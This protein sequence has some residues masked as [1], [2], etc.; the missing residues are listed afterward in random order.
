[1]KPSKKTTRYLLDTNA[2][3]FWILGDEDHKEL[4]GFID[5]ESEKGNVYISNI[6]F[7]EIGLLVKKKRIKIDNIL[8][9]YNELKDYSPAKFI[10]PH[11]SEML[12]STLLP[13]FHKDPFDRLL[14][15]QAAAMDAVMVTSDNTIRKYKVKTIWL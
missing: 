7:L 12:T 2:F 13:D 5:A 10:D 9:W 6:S 3:I 14:V 8:L 4:A 1:M 15:A 11:P